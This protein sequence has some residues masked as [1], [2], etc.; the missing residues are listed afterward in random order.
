MIYDQPAVLD[1]IDQGDLID[2]CPLLEVASYI[3]SI[4]D[5]LEIK[6][7]FQRV[8][9]V[10]QTCDLANAKVHLG[11][12]ARVFDAQQLVDEGEYKPAD[13]KGNMRSMRV[14]GAYFLP[15]DTTLGLNEMVVD[16]RQLHTVK[17]EH[18]RALCADG[19]RRGRIKPLYREHLAKHLGDTYSRIGLPRPYE[20]L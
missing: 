15:A 11:V 20:T 1:P 9:V 19:Q 10:T 5:A 17:L 13:I 7:E 16:L 6:F 8:L 14:F 18:L 12:V 4:P 2:S 3:G